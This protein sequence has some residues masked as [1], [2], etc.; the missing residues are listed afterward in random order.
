MQKSIDFTDRYTLCE[1]LHLFDKWKPYSDKTR[2]VRDEKGYFVSL[3]Y[4]DEFLE[5]KL[6]C[7]IIKK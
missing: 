3:F 7:M 5:N 4:S 2:V 1:A 6:K